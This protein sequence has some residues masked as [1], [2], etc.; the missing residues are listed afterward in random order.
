MAQAIMFESQTGVKNVSDVDGLP[1]AGYDRFNNTNSANVRN[2]PF[3]QRTD[4]LPLIVSNQTLTGSFA[5]FGEEIATA[6]YNWL[7][8]F[9]SI[10]INDSSDVRI[11]ALGKIEPSGAM[12][13]TLDHSQFSGTNCSVGAADDYLELDADANQ[14]IALRIRLDNAVP[15]VQLQVAAG[16]AGAS[17]AVISTASCYV[18]GY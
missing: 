13:T 12:E 11:K 1:I 14:V 3:T 2:Q 17:P 18:L 16:T 5:D 7:Y 4:G 10:T 8:V 9:L 6:G 15:Y